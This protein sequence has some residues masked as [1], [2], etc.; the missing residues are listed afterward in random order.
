MAVNLN[1]STGKSIHYYTKV[2]RESHL[3]LW[4]LSINLLVILLFFVLVFVFAV[5]HPTPAYPESGDGA[6]DGA[7]LVADLN[8]AFKIMLLGF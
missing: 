6:A 4:F 7:L 5:N 2:V 8:F 1:R 3:S